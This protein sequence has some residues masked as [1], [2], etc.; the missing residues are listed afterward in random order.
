MR[1][2]RTS[3]SRRRF[4]SRGTAGLLALASTPLIGCATQPG[5]GEEDMRGPGPDLTPTP[6]CEEEQ[7]DLNI[8]GPYYTANAPRR[9]SL[10]EDGVTGPLLILSGRV[11]SRASCGPL[12]GA[13]I[14][15]WQADASGA[16]DLE[17]YKLRGLFDVDAQGA[18]T[19][20]TV[21]PGRYLNGAT[22]RPRHLHVKVRAPDRPTLT[23]QL[24]FPDDPFNAADD[25]FL[26]SLLVEQAQSGDVTTARFDLVLA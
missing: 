24:Y 21:L 13:T 7:T 3:T 10:V 4:L 5:A 11:L 19:V 15:L 14:D 12:A 16:Y 25:F 9:A 23:T 2:A 17:G 20:T 18:Y 26:S 22:Y 6:S 8:E 1:H